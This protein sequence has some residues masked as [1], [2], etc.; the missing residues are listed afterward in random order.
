MFYSTQDVL[1][2]RKLE[3]QADLQQ[4]IELQGRTLMG[5]QL[6]DVKRHNHHR[7]LSTGAAIPS[8]I[9]SPNF[10]DQTF[11]LPSD[12]SK[13][14]SN[15]AMATSATVVADQLQHGAN[16]T[17]KEREPSNC[18]DEN[19]NGKE[20][21]HNEEMRLF[22]QP[23]KPC[24]SLVLAI[25]S[26]KHRSFCSLRLLSAKT[27]EFSMEK[28]SKNQGLCVYAGKV[29]TSWISKPNW[30][31]TNTMTSRQGKQSQA[32]EKIS[33][34]KHEDKQV[35]SYQRHTEKEK[36]SHGKYVEKGSG[37]VG[38]KDEIKKSSTIKIGNKSG[39]TEYH[40]EERVRKVSYGNNS[41]SSRN[42][43]SKKA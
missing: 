30:S 6:L 9:N 31:K 19:G 1:W 13:N 16:V 32:Y 33:R 28:G 17:E 22:S 39:Y 25:K 2:R 12:R 26:H 3:E 37:Q 34:V 42:Y 5:L 27:L 29:Q 41:S 8:P 24:H 38:V 35:G 43:G 15:P 14:G 4:A 7:T 18:N 36:V 40:R 23:N 21:P 11:V 10:F 20:S